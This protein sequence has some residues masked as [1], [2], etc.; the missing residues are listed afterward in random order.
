I[1]TTQIEFFRKEGYLIVEDIL[2]PKEINFYRQVY[3]DFLDGTID[4]QG[5]R[6]DLSG[7]TLG[8]KPEKIVQIMRPS[9]LYRPLVDSI[10][11]QRTQQIAQRLL[12]DDLAMDF[13][14]LIDKL[15]H[16]NTPTPWHQDEAYWID[17]PDKR[18]VSAWVALDNVTK[19]NGCMWFVPQSNEQNLRLHQQTGKGGALQCEAQESEAV[20]AEIS[21]GS[22]TFHSGRTIHYARGNSTANRRRAFICNFRP[23]A[24]IA[25]E[26]SQG[27]DHL[28]KRKV[29]Q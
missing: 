11:H 26:R 29:R 20:A 28:G 5:Q 10:L 23:A 12:G 14:M 16:T 8:G 18:A 17:M 3:E 1:T 15:P 27:F 2:K 9:L 21:A 13:D 24:M 22:C 19:E 4:A 6:S 7:Q 25:Y